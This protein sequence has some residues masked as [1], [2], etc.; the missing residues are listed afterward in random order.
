MDG[1]ME[2][3]REWMWA[4][5][6]RVSGWLST[7]LCVSRVTLS[8]THTTREWTSSGYA[9]REGSGE[10]DGE[11][12][13]DG[14]GDTARGRQVKV[15][16]ELLLDGNWYW[17]RQR[18]AEKRCNDGRNEKEDASRTNLYDGMCWRDVLLSSLCGMFCVKLIDTMSSVVLFVQYVLR[19]FHDF[20]VEIDTSYKLM[21]SVMEWDVGVDTRGWWYSI[22]FY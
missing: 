12:V 10:R 18:L 21:Q 2:I 3:E 11:T 22:Y 13:W 20:R 1:W 4:H 15:R 7:M 9:V 6:F 14:S 16:K 17:T 8:C 5:T 19:I